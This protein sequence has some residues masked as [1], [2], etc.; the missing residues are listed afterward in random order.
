M[1][2][3]Q[4][5]SVNHVAL[6]VDGRQ[7]ECVSPDLDENE[8]VRLFGEGICRPVSYELSLASLLADRVTMGPESSLLSGSGYPRW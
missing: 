4:S 7:S 6:V 2:I 3:F 8:M 1:L 5:Q